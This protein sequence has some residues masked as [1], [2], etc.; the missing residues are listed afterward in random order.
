MAKSTILLT[1]FALGCAGCDSA[2][3]PA[4]QANAVAT[5]TAMPQDG[6]NSATTANANALASAPAPAPAPA[7]SATDG[8]GAPPLAGYVGKYPL[9]KL[10]GVAFQE[11]PL[12][13]AGVEKAVADKAIRGWVLKDDSGPN[14][15]TALKDGRL[16]SWRCQ[17][18]NCGDHN[19]TVLID[20][21]TAAT[22]VCYHKLELTGEGSRWYRAG[23][24]PQD[25]AEG[26]PSE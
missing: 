2:D 3:T 20:P 21:A 25:R 26:C 17:Q 4:G 18:H 6:A 1:M 22:E 14:T 7:P 24:A 12:V 8:S 10:N 5:N 16:L 9:E 23:A 15:A 13:V 19:W 11:H